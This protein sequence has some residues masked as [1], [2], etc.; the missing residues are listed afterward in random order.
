MKSKLS[1][2]VLVGGGAGGLELVAQLG[3]KFGRRNKA[4]ITLV[5]ASLTHLW[6]PLLHEVAAGNFNPAEDEL[7]YLI[8]AGH[9]HFKFCLGTLEGL[10]R[11]EKIIWLAP[12][13]D[14]KKQTI[15]PQRFLSYDILIVAV[16][17]IANDFNTPGVREHCLFLDNRQQAD[18]FQQCLLKHI[19]HFP[20][21]RSSESQSFNLAI[22]GGGATGVELVAELHYAIRQM[23]NYGFNLDFKNVSFTL[24]ESSNRLL[25]ALP[26]HLSM[27]VTKQLQQ[28]G[29][30]I[31][32]GARVSRVTAEGL[33]VQ[34]DQ[35]IPAAMK[36]WAAG[37]KAPD[38][39]K[40]FDGLAVN[41]INQLLV[42][43]TLQTTLDSAI[44]AFGDCANCPQPGG[45]KFVPP[46][47][48]A[49]HQ[50]ASFLV[51]A[52]DNYLHNKPLPSYHYYDYGSLISLS[53][54]ETIGN[55]MGKITKGILLEGKLARLFYLALYKMH[56]IALYGLW[57]VTLLTIANI[58]SHRVRPR[59]KLH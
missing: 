37:I 8:Y 9:H 41:S 51:K 48:Q 49:A 36:V 55:L 53:H 13:L 15:M 40:N 34:S 18:Y 20:Y 2:I 31:Y 4:I 58:L 56:Q 5:D 35:F 32:T 12:I 14:E 59:L 27:M 21:Q 54:Y 16:G 3:R 23:A 1:H 29:V 38:F 43:P 7:N 57:R 42:K 45:N 44:F 30:K 24:I 33:F 11:G 47:A 19:L 25:P 26:Q 22:V 28:L 46:R 52:L 50:Q 10:N 39:L 6:K 17:S